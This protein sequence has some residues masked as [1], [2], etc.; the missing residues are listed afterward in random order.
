LLYGVAPGGVPQ[1]EA[2]FE[3]GCRGFP[4][5]AFFGC[6]GAALAPA[7]SNKSHYDSLSTG[8][9]FVRDRIWHISHDMTWQLSDSLS[10]RSIT[11][12]HQIREYYAQDTDGTP[13]Q[14]IE[15]NNP[16]CCGLPQDPI[17]AGPE[18][19][20]YSLTQ[21]FD[22]SGNA[23]GG[24]LNYLTGAFGSW[25]HGHE[26]QYTEIFPLLLGTEGVASQL[27]SVK[28]RSSAAYGQADFNIT[29]KLSI[30]LACVIPRSTS[31]T[32]LRSGPMD[33][34]PVFTTAWCR[35]PARSPPRRWPTRSVARS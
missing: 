34:S 33:C 10:L 35:P 20:D 30:T 28:S 4:A 29:N 3:A 6:A 26:Q 14:I 25:D 27:S 8:V 2:G 5:P 22:L 32:W 13:Y 23:I 12:Y 1:I 24:R 15:I 9:S 11:G 18:Q 31:P 19:A 16:L 17:K 7:I 21:E